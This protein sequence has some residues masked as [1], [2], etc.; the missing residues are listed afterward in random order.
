MVYEL[1]HQTRAREVQDRVHVYNIILNAQSI[2][3]GNFEAVHLYPH[4]SLYPRIPWHILYDFSAQIAKYW[5]PFN[6]QLILCY[7]SSC[8]QVHWGWWSN[9]VIGYRQIKKNIFWNK[10]SWLSLCICYMDLPPVCFLDF[11]TTLPTNTKIFEIATILIILPWS[12]PWIK[13]VSR[14]WL[15]IEL[16][17]Y[18]M[19]RNIQ[20]YLLQLPYMIGQITT[21]A[22]IYLP[23]HQT[24]N[25]NPA[26]CSQMI[27]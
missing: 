26:S 3:F 20:G 23:D 19:Q 5:Q 8:V 18:Y 16:V 7:L 15:G 4:H 25:H 17:T 21:K 2:K 13:P 22:S 11:V 27:G 10:L 6:C 24:K 12:S 1:L 14:Q 9:W